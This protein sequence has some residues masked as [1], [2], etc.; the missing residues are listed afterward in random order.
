MKAREH[1]AK[2]TQ[3]RQQIRG[4]G[5]S[6]TR[7]N[8]TIGVSG[9]IIESTVAIVEFGLLTIIPQKAQTETIII[10][11]ISVQDVTL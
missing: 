6:V 11:G 5:E 2:V 8:I 1:L 9:G 7:K 10:V 4:T 3:L